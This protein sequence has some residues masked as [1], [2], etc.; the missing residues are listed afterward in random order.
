MTH[1]PSSLLEMTARTISVNKVPYV[2]TDLPR[3]LHNYMSTSHCCVNPS[4]Q[5]VYFDSRVE[6]VKFVDFCGK[7]KIPLMQYLCSSR[8]KAERPAYAANADMGE[9]MKRVLLG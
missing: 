6:H 2:P 8:C 3:S 1:Q 5:G 9:K 7:Y 4:C